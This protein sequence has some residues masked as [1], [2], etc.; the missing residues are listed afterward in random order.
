M[1]QQRI[2]A[3]KGLAAQAQP[4]RIVCAGG[5]GRG[6]AAA[7]RPYHAEYHFDGGAVHRRCGVFGGRIPQIRTRLLPGRLKPR[8]ACTATAKET[9]IPISQVEF[10]SYDGSAL[11]VELHLKDEKVISFHEYLD[12]KPLVIALDNQGIRVEYKR[13]GKR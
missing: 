12:L 13:M 5:R 7:R 10:A 2:Y 8:C 9:I 4:R 3:W 11:G 6:L 1:N